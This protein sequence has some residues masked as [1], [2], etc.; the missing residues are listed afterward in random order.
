MNFAAAFKPLTKDDIADV[1][2]VSGRTIE[3]W[4]N[5]GTLPAPKRLG[6]RVYWHPGVFFGWL[7]QRLVDDSASVE[8]QS[9]A[10]EPVPATRR[11]ASP[12]GG[13]PAKTE[14]ERLRARDHAKLSALMG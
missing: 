13:K 2:G 7:E 4:V 10:P 1:L 5:D 11:T 9:V 14:V 3:N 8:A 12:R 6:N